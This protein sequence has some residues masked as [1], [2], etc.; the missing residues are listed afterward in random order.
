MSDFLVLEDG[1]S[2]DTTTS[3]CLRM[4][5]VGLLRTKFKTVVEY[6]SSQEVPKPLSEKDDLEGTIYEDPEYLA[7]KEMLSKPVE[8]LPSA[9]IQLQRREAERKGRENANVIITPLMEY[10][11][12][13]RDAKNDA[14]VYPK[15][16]C[17][18]IESSL[19]KQGDASIEQQV[20]SLV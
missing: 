7:F 19:D 16:T 6:A 14:Q 4:D 12:Q 9:E 5:S 8:K 10:I 3:K 13:Q 11:R 18:T 17:G 15:A 20:E 2:L 1:Q